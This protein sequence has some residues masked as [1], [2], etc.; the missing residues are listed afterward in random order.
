M[1]LRSAVYSTAVDG[2]HPT[3]C[4]Y[5]WLHNILQLLPLE[6]HTHVLQG[7]MTGLF[8]V[9][10]PFYGFYWRGLCR[11]HKKSLCNL[12]TQVNL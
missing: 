9:W 6:R 5:S 7:D 12:G 8:S 3:I 1:V 2:Q 11:N 10:N 4:L